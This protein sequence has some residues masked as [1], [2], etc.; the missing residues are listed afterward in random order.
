M[1]SPKLSHIVFLLVLLVVPAFSE[2]TIVVQGIDRSNRVIFLL[3]CSGS[4]HENGPTMFFHG[5]IITSGGQEHQDEDVNSCIKNRCKIVLAIQWMQEIAQDMGD[6]GY[7]KF[8]AFGDNVEKKTGWIQLPDADAI[9]GAVLWYFQI[10]P[11]RGNTD[12][13]KALLTTIEE[14]PQEGL[15]IIL[16]TDMEDYQLKESKVR[17]VNQNR[18]NGPMPIS[19]IGIGSTDGSERDERARKITGQS[20][21]T[22]LRIN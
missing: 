12:I 1:F 10:N 15:S 8:Y 14:N 11:G 6:E 5:K 9:Q 13:T 7:V 16:I 22:Y 18:K 20:N 19:V 17:K 4:M 3:D 2:E 21:A